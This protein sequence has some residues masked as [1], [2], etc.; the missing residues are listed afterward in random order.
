[1]ALPSNCTNQAIEKYFVEGTLPE[2]GAECDPDMS[3]FDYALSL[4]AKA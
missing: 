1:M 4:E 3:A 2:V